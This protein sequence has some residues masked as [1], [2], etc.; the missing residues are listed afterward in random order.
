MA[1]ALAT[2]LAR[3]SG[4]EMVA[5][6]QWDA[7]PPWVKRTAS[8]AFAIASWPLGRA[9]ARFDRAIAAD[10]LPS[11][12]NGML[13][14][15]GAR[16][17]SNVAAPTCGPLVVVANHPGAYDALALMAAIGRRDLAIVAAD[18]RF[19]RALPALGTHLVFVPDD[20]R[21]GGRA[22]AVRRAMRHVRGGGALLHFGAGRIEPDASFA[23]AG[24]SLLAEWSAGTGAFLRA[25]AASRAAVMLAFV[26]GV[27]SARAKRSVVNRLAERRGIT[28]VAPLLQIAL[29]GYGDVSVRVS[30]TP[31]RTWDAGATETDA[32]ITRR[33]RD[34]ALALAGQR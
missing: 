8:S 1:D 17:T 4:D 28:T 19:L 6:L 11:A 26:S 16:W 20:A 2:T 24:E 3:L 23:T 34:A 27:H 21:D 18:R 5:A 12:A 10:G 32:P 31:P 33:A 15:L 29:P 14:A 25:A 7:A 22:T 9:L 13:A 30:L